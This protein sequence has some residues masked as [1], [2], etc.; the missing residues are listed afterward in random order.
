MDF[1]PE[2]L[3]VSPPCFLVENSQSEDSQVFR[4][5]NARDLAILKQ[6]TRLSTSRTDPAAGNSLNDSS[7]PR[8]CGAISC[9]TSGGEGGGREEG[10]PSRQQGDEGQQGQGGD[11]SGGNDS[12][13][14]DGG[15]D[16]DGGGGGG[17]EGGGGEAGG[18]DGD[19][20]GGDGDD[21]ENNDQDPSANEE[22]S[23]HS[24]EPSSS[25]DALPELIRPEAATSAPGVRVIVKD[26]AAARQ[27]GSGGS[28]HD[29]SGDN[30]SQASTGIAGDGGDVATD[31][32]EASTALVDEERKSTSSSSVGKT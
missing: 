15:G 18:G 1:T 21:N 30:Y 4:S 6:L 16:N 2:E 11:S 17:G 22:E 29:S 19:G 24:E 23:P 28:V 9:S 8:N 13:G 20:G 10:D 26:V 12:G 31:V 25:S 32:S 27:H 7:L 3:E 5:D 14:G